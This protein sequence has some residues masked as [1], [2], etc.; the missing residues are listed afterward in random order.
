MSK[1]I[2]G[3]ESE[4]KEKVL[5][6]KTPVLVDFFAD[7]CGPCRMLAPLV[8]EM[9]DEGVSIYKVNVDELSDVA[10][11]YGIT[12]IPCVI[13]FEGGSEKNRIVGLAEKEEIVGMI[14]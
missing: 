3:S 6:A 7:W 12:S 5:E 2:I 4:F 9:A 14:S 1:L 8:E 13:A 10:A 11:Q